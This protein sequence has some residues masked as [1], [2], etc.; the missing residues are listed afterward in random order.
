MTQNPSVRLVTEANL[1][2]AIDAK[3]A[4]QHDVDNATNQSHNRRR[5]DGSAT[6]NTCRHA[7]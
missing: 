1:P 4:T 7:R 5:S 3:I 2:A 6:R